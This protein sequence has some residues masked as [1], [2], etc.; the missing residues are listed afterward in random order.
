MNF[1]WHLFFNII[2]H[3]MA[4]KPMTITHREEVQSLYPTNIWC[5]YKAVL[6][7]LKWVARDVA[8]SC[9]KCKFSYHVI[10]VL[11]HQFMHTLVLFLIRWLFFFIQCLILWLTNMFSHILYSIN[12][13]SNRSFLL[14]RRTWLAE[15]RGSLLVYKVFVCLYCLYILFMLIF[16][17]NSMLLILSI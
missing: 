12:T 11:C 7:L 17:K 10:A 1:T 8:N 3:E 5:Q 6:V 15:I 16:S 4:I 13:I 2:R 9:R 14:F